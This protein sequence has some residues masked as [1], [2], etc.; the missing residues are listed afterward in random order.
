MATA[1]LLDDRFGPRLGEGGGARFPRSK[2]GLTLTFTL[3]ALTLLLS[4][5]LGVDAGLALGLLFSL[6]LLQLTFLAAAI[7]LAQ[8]AL[9]LTLTLKFAT[10][11]S[12]TLRG[13]GC[14]VRVGTLL[15]RAYWGLGDCIATCALDSLDRA[16]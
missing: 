14:R 7:F 13:T 10:G 15:V 1:I 9:S 5:S 4:D 2:L 3:L 6:L 16:A 11:L 12:V 8:L